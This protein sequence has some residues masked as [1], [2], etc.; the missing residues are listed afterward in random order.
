MKLSSVRRL[1]KYIMIKY[2]VADC[3]GTILDDQ[4]NIDSRLKEAINSLKEMNIGFTLASGRNIHLMGSII[5]ELALKLPFIT[6]NGGNIYLENKRLVNNA[7]PS[8]Y[9]GYITESLIHNTIPFMLY[10]DET[11]YTHL[12]TDKLA[13]F[14]ANLIG[15]TT[16]QETNDIM[17]NIASCFKITVDSCNVDAEL[18]LKL[19][20]LINENCPLINFKRSEGD[21]YTITNINATKGNALIKLCEYL[22]CDCREILCIGDN[23]NDVSM[24]KVAGYSAA[25][26]NSAKEVQD[27]ATFKLG[28]NNQNGVSEF[29]F[30]YFN[31]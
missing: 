25:M 15:K 28:L 1:K 8:D 29:L 30:D 12:T 26:G 4:K 27:E 3:D 9:I 5:N 6:D 17:Q 11:V 19:Q 13:F 24:F 14:K 23:Y 31:L 18:M 21:L 7:I 2:V 22:N 16:L 20:T 10:T